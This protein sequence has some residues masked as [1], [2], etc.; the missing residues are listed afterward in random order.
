M[1]ARR[2]VAPKEATIRKHSWRWLAALTL[3]VA[4][5][6][7]LFAL[8][9]REQGFRWAEFRAA[10]LGIDP[11]WLAGSAAFAL[12]SF[13]GRVLRWAVMLR[14][15]KRNVSHWG[16]FS[17]TAIGFTAIVLLGRPAELVR[18]FL[19]AVKEKVPFSSQVAAWMLE[20]IFDLLATLVIFGFALTQVRN[21]GVAVGPGLE[22]V[23]RV[24]GVIAAALGAICL[25]ILLLLRY[26]SESMRVR[27]VEA[28][29]FLP[30]ALHE[31]ANHVVG[32]FVQGVVATRSVANVVLL[33]AYTVL[34]W[35]LITG[36][37]LC[38]FK[39]F[40]SLSHM[41]LSGV[42]IF[43]GFVSFGSVIQ[44]PGIGG[45]MQ[46]VA[47]V[48][49]SEIFKTPLELA[50]SVALVVWIVTFVIILPVG[51]P[52]ILHEGINLRKIKEMEA[53]AEA[54]L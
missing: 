9:W 54:S 35:V 12:A 24:G 52:L 3:L 16:L 19:I 10:L 13:Y 4:A 49:L 43:M 47:I 29:A 40:P 28:L 30:P 5:A 48:V 2:A 11:V 42:L 26:F 18:P 46:L 51:V 14:P 8:R 36:C 33:L 44:I 6:L 27:L 53:Q 7:V 32:A 50:S 17:A 22:W 37:Y 41:T 15:Q 38:L 25:A 34:E 1:P 23:L 21:L 20:R 39:A 31:R 45:G